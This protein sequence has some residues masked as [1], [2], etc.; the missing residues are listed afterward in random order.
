MSLAVVDAS[1]NDIDRITG[2]ETFRYR[3]KVRELLNHHRSSGRDFT[4][5]GALGVR[6]PIAI[7]YFNDDVRSGCHGE[8]LF[9]EDFTWETFTTGYWE[10]DSVEIP[11]DAGP[12]RLRMGFGCRASHTNAGLPLTGFVTTTSRSFQLGSPV[13]ACLSVADSEG[14][15]TNACPAGEGGARSLKA[16]FVS[17]PEQHDGSGRVKVRV[18]FSEAI[19]ES[20]ENVGE[21]GVKVEGGRVTSVRRVDNRPGGGAAGRSA[22]RSGDGQKDG[23][24]DGERVWEFEIEPGSAEDLTMRIDGG[25]PCDEPGAICTADGRSLSEGIATT[26]VGPGPAPLTASFEGIP[27]AHDGEDA[28]HFRVAFSEEIGIGFRSMRDAS[29]TVDGGEVTGARRVDRRHDLWRIT[30]EPDGEGDV[31]VTLPGG[32]ECGVS[33]AICTR[34]GNRRQLANTP[35]ATVAGPVDEAAVAALTASFVQAPAEHDGKAAFK[36]RIAFSEGISISFRTFRDAS[37]SVSGGSVTKAKRVDR[38]KDLWEATVKPDSI[39]DVTVTL[40]GGRACGTPG[41]VCTGD[42]RALSATISTRV[43]GPPGLSVADA[44]VDEGPDA[45]L[46]FVVRLDR[47]PSSRVTVDYATADGTAKAGSDYTAVSG[48][49]TFAAGER[50]KTV[51][52][53]VLDDAHDEGSET[54]TLTLSNASG[55]YIEDGTATGTIK[56]TGHMPKA[57]LARFGRTVAEQVLDAVGARVEGNSNSPGPA[58][59]TL[60]GHQ[61]VLGASWSRGGGDLTSGMPASSG[62]T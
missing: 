7:E 42:G 6:G 47:A 51:S 28:F 62:R 46:A 36:L 35:A 58:R 57:W 15:V 59:L 43:L 11:A 56:N 61:V 22:G 50:A 25:R 38:R 3:V 16:R 41:A 33:G 52:V 29:F 32:R 40:E 45:A 2:G 37:L 14:T 30:V 60:G 26:V 21:H 39:G 44:E 18:A 48:A 54:L 49:L 13:R 24:E 10:F 12:V 19:E 8:T 9:L 55:A 27:E 31:T 53:A 17:P 1:G 5:W 20:P 4:G 23:Q 34:G